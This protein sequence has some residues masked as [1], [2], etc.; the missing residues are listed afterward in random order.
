MRKPAS[1]RGI[2]QLR[3]R[4]YEFCYGLDVFSEPQAIG[5]HYRMQFCC[6]KL[7]HVSWLFVVDAFRGTNRPI[8]DAYAWMNGKEGIWLKIAEWS[9]LTAKP[10][11]SFW[12]ADAHWASVWQRL[13]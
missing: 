11:Y 8:G 9:D 6:Q 13:A 3:S 10:V 12:D 2:W 1:Y 4:N 5:R 7:A